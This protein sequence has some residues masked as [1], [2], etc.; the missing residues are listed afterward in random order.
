MKKISYVYEKK[1][2]LKAAAARHKKRKIY[3]RHISTPVCDNR[4]K[5]VSK[6][7]MV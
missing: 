5:G 7:Y 4:F 1:V 6:K 2:I 3:G